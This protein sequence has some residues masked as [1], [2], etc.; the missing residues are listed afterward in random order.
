MGHVLGREQVED[1]MARRHRRPL[2]LIDLAVPRDVDPAV[3]SVPGVY[4][5][6]VDDLSAIAEAHRRRREAEVER[7][8][9]II[10][11]RVDGL[12]ESWARMPGVP[13]SMSAASS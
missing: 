12:L 4:L 11:A 1:W 3:I 6:N 5:F 8:Q 13:P 10:R 2:L 7:C 9:E